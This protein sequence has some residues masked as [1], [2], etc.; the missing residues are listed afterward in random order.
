MALSCR[1]PAD[2]KLPRL[3]SL[4]PDDPN[5]A[6]LSVTQFLHALSLAFENYLAPKARDVTLKITPAL[7]TN[8]LLEF[9]V[10]LV[11]M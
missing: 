2:F 3:G 10:R 9:I 8:M 1:F 6:A 4:G 5:L 7:L 11:T